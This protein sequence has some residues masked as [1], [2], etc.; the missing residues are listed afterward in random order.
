MNVQIYFGRKNFDTQ[1]AERYF[2]ERK[3]KIQKIDLLKV[4]M[5][6]GEFWKIKQAVGLESLIDQDSKA[7][8][9]YNMAYFGLS[10]NTEETLLEHPEIFKTPIVRNGKH[11]TVGYTPEIWASWE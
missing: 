10:P 3:I 5:S 11:A 9:Q 1:K 7:Y 4:G 6:K 2:K 8:S